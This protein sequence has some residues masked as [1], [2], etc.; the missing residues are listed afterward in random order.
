MSLRTLLRKFDKVELRKK[1]ESKEEVFRRADKVQRS[2]PTVVK[3]CGGATAPIRPPNGGSA[4]SPSH[5]SPLNP[6]LAGDNSSLTG[7]MNIS[8]V[9]TMNGSQ[10]R[11]QNSF[12]SRNIFD[13]LA[14]DDDGNSDASISPGRSRNKRVPPP[15]VVSHSDAKTLDVVKNLR[16]KFNGKLKFANTGIGLKVL[17]AKTR[18]H[19][20]I[21]EWLVKHKVQ[22]YSH[23]IRVKPHKK[24]TVTGLFDFNGAEDEIK[25][26]LA[27]TYG[28]H[29]V[30][31]A[32]IPP[33]N[34]RY[35]DDI[36]YMVAFER[37]V[38][39]LTQ[40]RSVQT[41]YSCVVKWNHYKVKSKPPTQ[42]RNCYLYGHGQRNCFLPPKCNKC[43]G[44]HQTDSCQN[45]MKCRNCSGPHTADD[46]S[47]PSR[48]QF[49][50]MR[51]ERGGHRSRRTH[52]P[53]SSRHRRNAPAP[54][55]Q[56]RRPVA[57]APSQPL[58]QDQRAGSSTLNIQQRNPAPPLNE[59]NFPGLPKPRNAPAPT[60][61]E[62]P[63]Q[64]NPLQG[65]HDSSDLFTPQQL[66]II[67]GELLQD[68]R[69]CTSKRDQLQVLF[70]IL[71]KY[72]ND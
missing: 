67:A 7:F 59:A 27:Q 40:L 35:T 55:S 72:L 53:T 46:E 65:L 61:T 17:C 48:E 54:S 56:S 58:P 24:F 15:I 51:S 69:G 70:N 57:A 50:R 60:A 14:D 68:L 19:S 47:C 37:G 43:G 36:I 22:F 6:A 5:I 71:S 41:L 66:M 63:M 23:D 62:N 52:T 39:N 38:V 4:S 8:P 32:K 28:L 16:A 13:E 10:S 42:C 64:R 44:D 12:V 30:E 29:T 33:K 20:A 2:P 45:T 21:K 11:H 18:I 31:V 34:K 9:T 26:E 1:V 3:E 49:L 25:N